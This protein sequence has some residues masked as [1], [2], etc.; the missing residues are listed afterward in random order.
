MIPR[1]LIFLLLAVNACV[2]A[3]T[4]EEYAAKISPLIEPAKLA[5]LGPRAANPR[6]QKIVYWLA[7]AKAQGVNPPRVVDVALRTVGMTNT[8]SAAGLEEMRQGRAATV[9][10]GPYAG[11]QLS[12]DH[13]IPRAVVPELDNVI[14]NLE[15]L[16]QRAN[17]RKNSTV[18]QRQRDLAEKLTTAGLLSDAGLRAIRSRR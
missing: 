18:G 10:R 13:I 1:A 16:P 4:V 6:V 14:A 17:A 5:T 8:A 12:V 11:D 3:G 7:T 15:L 2:F 9:R